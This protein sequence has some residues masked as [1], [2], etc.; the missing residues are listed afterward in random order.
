MYD[1]TN[2]AAGQGNVKHSSGGL[3]TDDN[4][5][6]LAASAISPILGGAAPNGTNPDDLGGHKDIYL[7][8]VHAHENGGTD[9]V[10]KAWAVL[11]KNEPELA[12]L[13]SAGQG[14]ER[15][16]AW[17]TDEL[18]A[19]D[20]PEPAWI[21][22]GILPVGL[23][24]LSGRPKVGKSWLAMQIAVAVGSGGMVMERRV[25]KG[26]VLYLALEDNPRRLKNRLRKQRTPRGVSVTWRNEWTPFGDGGLAALE[27]EIDAGGYSLVIID[28]A[29]RAMVGQDH[30]DGKV[31]GP[32]YDKLQRIAIDREMSILVIDHFRKPGA[33][34]SDIINDVMGST[35]KS[36][37]LDGV[38][39]LIRENGQA[40]VYL[41]V[42]GRDVEEQSMVVKFDHELGCWQ[43]V[44]MEDDV[45]ED[46]REGKVL[47]C[48]ADG[49]KA[50]AT[51][52]AG[53]TG[54]DPSNARKI[55]KG[56]VGKGKIVQHPKEG[57][58]IPYSIPNHN[59]Q[60]NQNDHNNQNNQN[61]EGSD[62]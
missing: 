37:A 14:R 58:E 51:E 17:T 10:R 19:A 4:T 47:E 55:I 46:S 39:G 52:I 2:G 36:G 7:E 11:A 53:W 28:T 61:Q 33:Q 30:N 15:K 13:L 45:P 6:A 25:E 8:L 23:F 27:A 12:R 16:T 20:F 40:E 48:L 57:R 43:F 32:L 5:L 49:E 22:P 26:N 38:I 34:G 35:A 56:L 60:N 50:T 18:L 21:V 31:M 41:R 42:I 29:A 44:R 9:A 24:T 54:I 62:E 59:N 3:T 1:T